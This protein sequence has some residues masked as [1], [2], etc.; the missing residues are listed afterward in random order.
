MRHPDPNRRRA[1]AAVAALMASAVANPA[2]R[3][4]ARG[5]D[6]VGGGERELVEVAIPRAQGRH[7]ADA[8]LR[9][10]ARLA[11][12]TEAKCVFVEA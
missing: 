11:L 6:R 7:D 2:V 10:G 5:E 8:K 12:V 1:L 9:E 3:A 4:Q